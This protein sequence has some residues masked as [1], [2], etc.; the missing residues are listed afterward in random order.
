MTVT[1]VA[2]E[3]GASNIVE[4]TITG[5]SFMEEAGPGSFDREVLLTVNS[6]SEHAS[7][8]VMDT[9][10]V[11]SGITFNPET[12]AAATLAATTPNGG[13]PEAPAEPS[14]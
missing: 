12:P 9:T 4:F 3:T 6:L 1:P 8:W 13:A 10:E 11:P 2:S 14:E 5:L 7:A